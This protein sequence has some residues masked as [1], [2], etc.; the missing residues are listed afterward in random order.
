[1]HE[2]VPFSG[3]LIEVGRV[4]EVLVK[5]PVRKAGDFGVEVGY[6]VENQEEIDEVGNHNRLVPA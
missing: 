4:P 5:L 3:V 6:E 1:M 2:S